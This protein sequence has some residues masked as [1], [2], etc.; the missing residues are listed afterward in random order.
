MAQQNPPTLKSLNSE[1]TEIS[2]KTSQL[3]ILIKSNNNFVELCLKTIGIVTV[4][5]PI[6]TAIVVGVQVVIQNSRLEDAIKDTKIQTENT[7]NDFKRRT[8]ERSVQSMDIKNNLD[9]SDNIYAESWINP[10]KL[11]DGRKTYTLNISYHPRFIY[12]GSDTNILGGIF[13]RYNEIFIKNFLGE[14]ASNYAKSYMVGG[15]STYETPQ[16][17]TSGELYLYSVTL[18]RTSGSCEELKKIQAE[19]IKGTPGDVTL[20]PI[21][22]VSDAPTF[23]KTFHFQIAD[24]GI[25][26]CEQTIS[27]GSSDTTT[28]Q[29]KPANSQPNLPASTR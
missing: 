1:I 6:V 26:G 24:T 4:T 14:S 21:Y 27:N 5:L 2:A 29:I 3:E 19:L 9:D 17:V 12:K 7:I 10:H 22:Q 13:I 25:L 15:I 8:S 28:T 20:R 18:T 11:E 23:E 16:T